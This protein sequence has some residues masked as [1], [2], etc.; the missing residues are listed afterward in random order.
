MQHRLG[1]AARQ[2]LL[3]N[4]VNMRDLRHQLQHIAVILNINT[5]GD[6]KL[7]NGFGSFGVLGAYGDLQVSPIHGGSFLR[8][9]SVYPIITATEE[10]L[11]RLAP[12]FCIAGA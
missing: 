7:R 11:N 12:I 2:Q 8:I 9:N 6:G 5:I 3:I 1:T 4:K 10:N